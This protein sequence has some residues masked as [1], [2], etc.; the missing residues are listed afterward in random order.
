M[1]NDWQIATRKGK[2]KTVAQITSHALPAVADLGAEPV[3]A[4]W[5][6]YPTR[7]EKEVSIAA[8]KPCDVPL[9]RLQQQVQLRLDEL[10]KSN[11]L[12]SFWRLYK[13]VNDHALLEDSSQ[14]CPSDV[15]FTWDSATVF[16]IYG[17]GS[18]AAGI[19]A[20]QS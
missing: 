11:F 20:V 8:S 3:H 16:V 10:Q 19:I 13:H 6:V 12:H 7:V 5:N 1:S 15:I 17:L 4:A 2:K 14:Q 9:A 18:P